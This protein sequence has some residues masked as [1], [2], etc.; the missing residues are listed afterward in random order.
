VGAAA[1]PSLL[2]GEAGV[3]HFYLRLHSDETPSVLLLRAPNAAADLTQ[4]SETDGGYRVLQRRY[5]RTFFGRTLD[6]LDSLSCDAGLELTGAPLQIAAKTSD[7]ERGYSELEALADSGAHRALI[8]DAF[9]PERKRYIASLSI[10]DFTDELL[11]TLL[12]ES[13]DE[14]VWTTE[15][16]Q[17]APH[18]HLVRTSRD[19][20]TWLAEDSTERSQEPQHIESTFLLYRSGNRILL[21]TLSPFAAAVLSTMEQ[22]H[23]IDEISRLMTGAVEGS[24]DPEQV[25]LAVVAQVKQAWTAGLIMNVSPRAPPALLNYSIRFHGKPN[26]HSPSQKP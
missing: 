8:K 17:L 3:G 22:P 18:T 23:S 6:I 2:L 26:T 14:H 11:S 9:R 7:V 5:V 12:R 25:R 13:L 19:W 10:T 20:E 24:V 1:D 15:P 16:L 4:I 21:R